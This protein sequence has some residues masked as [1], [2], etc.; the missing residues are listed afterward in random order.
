MTNK[1]FSKNFLLVEDDDVFA[2]ILKK[3]LETY[4]TVTV[5]SHYQEASQLITNYKF[6]LCFLD[7]WLNSELTGTTLLKL[8][9]FN[10]TPTYIISSS[11]DLDLAEFCLKN[12]ATEFLDKK[13]FKKQIERIIAQLLNKNQKS[14][15]EEKICSLNNLLIE[16][17]NHSLNYFNENKN[18]F[19]TGE[20]GVGKTYFAKLLHDLSPLK[21][22]PFIHLNCAEVPENLL[23]SE[24][25]GYKKGAFTD[26]KTDQKGKLELSNTGTL[27]LDEVTSL[28]NK[29]QSKLLKV[30]EDKEFYPLGST[31]KCKVSFNLITASCENIEEFLHSK[32]LRHDFYFRIAHHQWKI[33]ALKD[34]KNDIPLLIKELTK[35]LGKKVIFDKSA[36]DIL[37]NYPWPGNIRELQFTLEKISSKTQ[38]IIK[39]KDVLY[40]INQ[41]DCILDHHQSEILKN[42]GLNGLVKKLEQDITLKHF[43]ANE[44]KIRP[45][46]KELKISST[47]LYRILKEAKYDMRTMPKN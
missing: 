41:Q 8:L 16:E 39:D 37:I 2:I 15:V 35:N 5:A 20:T 33:P 42:Y 19:L 1:I 17:A 3:Q 36:L 45:T 32:N 10:N 46:L 6:D 28:S 38:G 13:N 7:L 40:L 23:E 4:G 21:Q 24:L 18:I 22:K 29:L 43:I 27:F 34:R 44:C 26:A 30:L 47:T 12:G 14:K 9:K 25:F 11:E 31:Q